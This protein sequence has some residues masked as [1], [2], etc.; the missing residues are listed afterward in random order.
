MDRS[1]EDAEYERALAA[2]SGL[3]SGRQ[4]RDSGQWA[5]AFEMMA[6]YLEASPGG[7]AWASGRALLAP[8]RAPSLPAAPAGAMC[9]PCGGTAHPEPPTHTA[10]AAAACCR[11]PPPVRSLPCLT[12]LGRFL[13][14][15]QRL[16]LDAQLP[17][18]SVIHVAGTKGKGSTCAMV[19]RALRAAGYRTGL[20]TSPHLIDVRERIRINGWVLGGGGFGGHLSGAGEGRRAGRRGAVRSLAAP[21]CPPSPRLHCP[22][23]LPLLQ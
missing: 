18:L 22:S 7:E 16:G 6:S 3:I 9:I 11:L 8:R 4:R 17:R 14:P 13:S 15:L 20:F 1:A 10:A 2:L 5:H 12:R 23:L 21:F 19:E